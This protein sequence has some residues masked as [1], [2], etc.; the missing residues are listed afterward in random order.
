MNAEIE[1]IVDALLQRGDT[2]EAVA[3]ALGMQ[4]RHVKCI[5][6]HNFYG[7]DRSLKLCSFC[8]KNAPYYILYK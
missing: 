4:Y 6:P 7:A 5:T 1:R 2:P 3:T 8:P